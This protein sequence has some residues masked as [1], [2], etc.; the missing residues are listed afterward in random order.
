[1]TS[2]YTSNDNFHPKSAP[3]PDPFSRNT[4]ANPDPFPTKNS[5]ANFDPY[6]LLT[7]SSQPSPKLSPFPQWSQPNHY[8]DPFSTNNSSVN[9][10]STN[11]FQKPTKS[12]LQE[13]EE[14][15]EAEIE[16]DESGDLFSNPRM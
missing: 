5:Q 15:S 11:G 16:N 7:K 1:L 8:P 3:N 9:D 10:S 4:Q 14:N 13:R 12:I 6:P 2:D